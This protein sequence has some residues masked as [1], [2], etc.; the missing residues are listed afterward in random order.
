MNE[1]LENVATAGRISGQILTAIVGQTAFWM[2]AGVAGFLVG[3]NFFLS[4][5]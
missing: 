4:V 3:M 1:A 5:L 2:L